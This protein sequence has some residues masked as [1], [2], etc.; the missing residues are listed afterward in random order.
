MIPNGNTYT[1]DILPT[2]Y[3]GLND[4]GRMTFI[5]GAENIST[6]D[7]AIIQDTQKGTQLIKVIRL[8]TYGN[9]TP[10][11]TILTLE[12]ND[13]DLAEPLDIP[14][15][16]DTNTTS[17]SQAASTTPAVPTATKAPVSMATIM[18]GLCIAGFIGTLRLRR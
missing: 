1:F 9:L 10:K 3:V 4:Y 13:E 11:Y 8:T 7:Y 14:F 5:T 16:F 2:L 18:A 15:G 12:L 17:I 6:G